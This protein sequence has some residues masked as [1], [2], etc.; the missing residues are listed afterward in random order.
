MKTEDL[1]Q[2]MEKSGQAPEQVRE[3]LGDEVYE[4]YK[5]E[6]VGGRYR[7]PD[8]LSFPQKVNLTVRGALHN[9][10]QGFDNRVTMDKLRKRQFP[11][12]QDFRGIL[13]A[14]WD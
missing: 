1:I 12:W 14:V 6:K 7:F 13:D 3:W 2:R 8:E 11:N 10:V 5:P 9:A 4:W